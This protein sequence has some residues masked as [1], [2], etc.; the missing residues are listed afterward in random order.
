MSTDIET[1]IPM[2]EYDRDVPRDRAW[3]WTRGL[4][5]TTVLASFMLV[6]DL[7]PLIEPVITYTQHR[8]GD[9]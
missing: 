7:I 8:I 9:L 4:L 2:Y 1:R 6:A 3:Y 5:V